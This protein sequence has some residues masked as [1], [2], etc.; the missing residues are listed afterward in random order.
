MDDAGGVCRLHH[1]GDLA[2][3]PTA[4]GEVAAPPLE[5]RSKRLALQELHHAVGALVGRDAEVEDLHDARA[6]DRGGGARL[7]EEP[8]DH[9]GVVA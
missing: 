9:V 2:A 4:L 6:A 5:P 7:V 1:V 8:L 3:E